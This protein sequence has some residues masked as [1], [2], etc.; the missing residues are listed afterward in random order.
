MN[1]N[2]KTQPWVDDAAREI[3][4][5]LCEVAGISQEVKNSVQVEWFN[6]V[7]AEII[8]RHARTLR[9]SEDAINQGI[10]EG[11]AACHSNAVSKEWWNPAPT[12]PEA[13]MLVVSELAEALED[14]RGTLEPQHIH[15]TTTGKPIG[16]PVEMADVI[17]RVFDICG[18]FEIPLAEAVALK[19]AYN[20]TR[21]I[22]H[23]GKKL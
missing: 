12:F 22:R 7:I 14:Y 13:L 8:I 21:P 2:Y 18:G 20:K 3:I 6:D 9:T 16:I 4:G 19:M 1:K 10:S 15:Q 23:G 11:V 5:K 17:I